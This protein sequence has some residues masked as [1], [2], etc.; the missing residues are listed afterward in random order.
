MGIKRNKY[1]QTQNDVLLGLR[2]QSRKKFQDTGVASCVKKFTVSPLSLY[3]KSTVRC[4]RCLGVKRCHA[5]ILSSF[6]KALHA[7]SSV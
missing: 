5:A 4:V 7:S 2:A 3:Q 1:L 6:K